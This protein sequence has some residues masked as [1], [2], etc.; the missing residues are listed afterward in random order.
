MMRRLGMSSGAVA[1]AAALALVMLVAAAPLRAQRPERAAVAGFVALRADV[2]GPRLDQP[3]TLSFT[4]TLRQAIARIAALAD[5]SVVYDDSLPGLDVRATLQIESVPARDVL[6][7]VLEQS[8]L[9][10]LVSP[11]GQIV[12]VRRD[13]APKATDELRGSVR[14]RPSRGRRSPAHESISVGTRFATYSP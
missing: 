2:H 6:L 12:L 3:V 5:L 11:S 14:R 7:R 4:G 8:T 9:R 10:A 13:G 1:S